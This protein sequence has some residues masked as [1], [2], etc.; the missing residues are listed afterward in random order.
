MTTIGDVMRRNTRLFPNRTA[1]VC[2]NRRAT[3]AS[4]NARV[5]QLAN[6]L[7]GEGVRHGERVMLILPPDLEILEAFGACEKL[8]AIAVPVNT[9]LHPREIADVMSDCE[10]AAILY[11]S[12][13]EHLVQAGVVQIESARLCCRV[14]EASAPFAAVRSY[15]DM[16]AT[17]ASAEPDR[18]AV[19]DDVAYLYYTSGTTG[20][21][22]GVMQTHRSTVN[23]GRRLMLELA[24]RPSDVPLNY[25]PMFH[26]GGR[27]AAFASFYRGCTA[28][29]LPRFDPEEYLRTAERESA[30][31]LF[32]VPTTVKMLLE[33]G[34]RT[35]VD[36]RSV[37]TM[38][39]SGAPANVPL[40]RGVTE[41]LG[42]VLVQI[43]GLS[44]TGPVATI[45]RREDHAEA[46][47]CGND[48][49]LLSAGRPCLDVDVRVVGPTGN[50]LAPG[51]VGE[52][53]IASDAL[54]AGYWRQP[55]LTAEA[56]RDGWLYTGDLGTW[57]DEGYL[58]LVDR[59]KDMIVSG[60]ENVF[61][62]EVEDVLYAHPAVAEAAVIGVPDEHWGEVPIAFV[63]AKSGG[64]PTSDDIAAFCLE[65]IASYKRPR[66]VVIVSDL[67]K[68][69]IGKID[70]KKLR[71][72]YW[73]QAPRKI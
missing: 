36:L 45:L 9:R 26:I 39:Y 21:P 48:R 40:L 11:D 62:R 47:A 54:M 27:G 72:T 67:P 23:N 64:V 38:F 20:K 70:K 60:A 4:F 16:L 25:G 57:D 37:H 15:E 30:T 12:R 29:I 66:R 56:L 43:Y 28:H 61:P 73:S 52:I 14:G 35:R 10:P 58:Y 1:F 13:F 41:W 49:R 65:R 55:A 69:S 19:P 22:K 7:D 5:N 51:E 59:K 8:G 34:E 2:G 33:S 32:N 50:D 68:N 6:A 71:D 17:G 24:L 31:V 42:N 53:L 18:K 46:I 44:E 3:F 63:V